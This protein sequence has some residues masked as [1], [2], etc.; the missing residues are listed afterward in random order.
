MRSASLARAP[1]CLA[2]PRFPV[3]QVGNI[4]RL[5]VVRVPLDAPVGVAPRPLSCAFADMLHVV[6]APQGLP[7]A[8]APILDCGRPVVGRL[9]A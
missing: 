7:S 5:A 1:F 8:D 2:T 6:I 3:R 9:V 4:S